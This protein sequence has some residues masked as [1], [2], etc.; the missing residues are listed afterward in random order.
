MTSAQV[1]E[2]SVNVISNSPSQD[3]THPDD[4]TLLHD[5]TPGFKPFTILFKVL[6]IDSP[7]KECRK[8]H[9]KPK[10]HKLRRWVLCHFAHEKLTKAWNFFGKHATNT[11]STEMVNYFLPIDRLSHQKTTRITSRNTW[12]FKHSFVRWYLTVKNYIS[13]IFSHSLSSQGMSRY[14]SSLTLPMTK[15]TKEKNSNGWNIMF[16]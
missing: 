11:K 15:K 14:F 4:R 10:L 6:P 8:C 13:G 2:T 9:V 3:Y 16:S 7:K 1:V 5:M 12:E